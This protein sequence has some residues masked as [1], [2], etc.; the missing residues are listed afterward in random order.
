MANRREFPKNIGAAAGGAWL[1]GHGL[2]AG[3]QSARSEITIN[4]RRITTVDIH[5]HAVFPELSEVIAGTPFDLNFP[6]W[7]V[8]GPSRIEA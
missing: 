8:L 4:G 7:Q 5:A 1:M 2:D 6:D 3:A